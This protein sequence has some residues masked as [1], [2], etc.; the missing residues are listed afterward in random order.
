[1]TESNDRETDPARGTPPIGDDEVEKEQTQHP[2][3]EEDVGAPSDED[4]NEEEKAGEHP[5]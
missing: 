3:P 5:D 2:A 4:L 1:M